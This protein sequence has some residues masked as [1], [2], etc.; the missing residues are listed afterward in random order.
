ML[1]LYVILTSRVKLN[2]NKKVLLRERKRHT[3]RHV[4]ST[5]YVVLS[6]LTP[7]PPGWTWPPPGRLD[8]T[9]PLA[10]WTWL[11]PPGR[12][13]LTP[14]SQLDL[15]P[16]PGPDPPPGWLDLTPPREQTDRHVSK[17]NLPVVLRT[18]AVKTHMCAHVHM[19]GSTTDALRWPTFWRLLDPVCVQTVRSISSQHH[20][21]VGVSW[22]V[23]TGDV[24]DDIMFKSHVIFCCDDNL[25]IQK[26]LENAMKS[27]AWV[28]KETLQILSG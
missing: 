2:G 12:L 14:P 8:L 11:P 1:K 22:S 20:S 15:T 18:R 7:P 3:A 6:W 5:P 21:E 27:F 28:M 26:Y 10:G 24:R 16:L 19:Y 23:S 13:D 25:Q 9:P 4:A 17:H